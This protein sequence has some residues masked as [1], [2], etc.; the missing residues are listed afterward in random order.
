MLEIRRETTHQ[1]G[2]IKSVSQKLVG[3]KTIIQEGDI[4]YLIG[5]R[6]GNALCC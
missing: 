3:P 1:K 2:I 5:E 4:M 6:A